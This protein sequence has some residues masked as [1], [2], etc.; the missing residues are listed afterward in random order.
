MIRIG[1]T[2]HVHLTTG[3]TKP[4]YDAILTV[5]RE[6]GDGCVR[7]VT[8]LADGADQIFA[9]A[10]LATSGSYEVILPAFD[11]RDKQIRPEAQ[12]DFDELVRNA[13]TVSYTG[14][15]RSGDDAYL[16][17]SLEMLRR[18]DRLLAVWDGRAG[19][20]SGGTADVVTRARTMRLPVTVIWPDGAART[21]AATI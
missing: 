6:Y 2:G 10:V 12:P 7:G 16:D 19:G 11:Y 4:I 14:H 15:A 17:A 3:S 8:C 9:R 21:G 13:T 1:I 20:R 5:L 18:C